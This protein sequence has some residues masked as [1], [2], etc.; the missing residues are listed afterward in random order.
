MKKHI[1]FFTLLGSFC[2]FSFAEEVLRGAS[3]DINKD[4]ISEAVFITPASNGTLFWRTTNYRSVSAASPLIELGKLGDNIALAQWREPGR[5]SPAILTVTPENKVILRSEGVTDLLL[6]NKEDT[7]ISGADL[8][9]NGITDAIKLSEVNGRLAWQITLNP[10]V[11]ATPVTKNVT[12]GRKADKPFFFNRSGERDILAVLRKRNGQPEI[13][14][15]SINSSAVGKISLRRFRYNKDVNK[16]LGAPLPLKSNSLRDNL[17]FSTT[18]PDGTLRLT[19][20][21]S[22]G[23]VRRFMKGFDPGTLVVGNYLSGDVSEEPLI[24]NSTTGLVTGVDLQ[25]QTVFY[26]GITPGGIPIDEI[27]INSF[28]NASLNSTP[29]PAPP[30]CPIVRAPPGECEGKV[31]RDGADGFLWKPNSSTMFFAVT[32][33][34]KEFTQCIS[35]VETL[36]QQGVVINE[37]TRKEGTP[38]GGREAYQDFRFTGRQYKNAYGSIFVKASL[39]K[40][41]CLVYSVS[42][43]ARR[44]D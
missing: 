22:L 21:D 12:F 4:G 7:F 15:R 34:P 33:F 40:G 17:L 31:A 28:N 32:L 44:I 30:V 35:K 20:V 8:D 1:F 14:Y 9:G 41:G 36:N 10:F 3:N 26:L 39:F 5:A 19:K 25:L 13:L 42:D 2:N 38:N 18:E 27:N 29:T 16:E 24:V 6:G 43:P 37:L 23:R 11:S